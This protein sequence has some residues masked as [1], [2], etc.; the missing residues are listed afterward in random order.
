MT[1]EE[2]YTEIIRICSS[3]EYTREQAIEAIHQYAKD[4][5]D[6]QREEC[7]ELLPD[8]LHPMEKDEVLNAPYP[9]ELQ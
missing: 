6:K 8:R 5:C 2:K 7:W 1:P 9:K 4:M 3:A